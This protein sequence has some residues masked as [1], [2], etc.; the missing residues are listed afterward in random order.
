MVDIEPQKR[1]EK[2]DECLVFLP[3][4]MMSMDDSM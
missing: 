2:N 4:K 1:A 3:V